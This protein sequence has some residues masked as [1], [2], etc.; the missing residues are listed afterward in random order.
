MSYSKP[1]RFKAGSYAVIVHDTE[2]LYENTIVYVSSG[3]KNSKHEI[4]VVFDNN[5]YSVKTKY[6]DFPNPKLY[7]AKCNVNDR[8]TVVKMFH[9]FLHNSIVVVL[10]N[11][12]GKNKQIIVKDDRDLFGP[13]PLSNLRFA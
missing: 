7:T 2:G 10:C 3:L 6:L 11:Y 8:A 4:E 5:K 9:R 1:S 13:I 12:L